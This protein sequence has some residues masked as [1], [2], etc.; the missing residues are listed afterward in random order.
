MQSTTVSKFEYPRHHHFH[1]HHHQY[2]CQHCQDE[3]RKLL[4]DIRQTKN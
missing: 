1:H 4:W 3:V 2:H